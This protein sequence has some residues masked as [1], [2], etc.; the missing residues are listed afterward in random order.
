VA[1]KVVPSE[2]PPA[3]GGARIWALSTVGDH[4]RVVRD[5]APSPA[6]G[7]PLRRRRP[8]EH[9]RLML[10]ASTQLLEPGMARM[11]VAAF[12]A[13]MPYAS[14]FGIDF[15]IVA[16]VIRS[17]DPPA[18]QSRVAVERRGSLY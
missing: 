18:D 15:V 8:Q 12:Q 10:L 3:A 5:R 13:G 16:G 14:L 7:G 6:S 17:R 4:G 2:R 1:A 11:P 9:K